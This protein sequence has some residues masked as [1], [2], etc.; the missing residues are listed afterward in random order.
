M[1]PRLGLFFRLNN[2]YLIQQQPPDCLM[3]DLHEIENPESSLVVMKPCLELFWVNPLLIFRL[4]SY[5]FGTNHLR[6]ISRSKRE[7]G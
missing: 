1:I 3:V 2:T 6:S 5:H 4:H 7:M